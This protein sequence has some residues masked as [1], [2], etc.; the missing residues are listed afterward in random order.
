MTTIKRLV[1]DGPFER[2]IPLTVFVDRC[3]RR[4][5]LCRYGINDFEPLLHMYRTLDEQ[6]VSQGLPPR[7]DRLRAW[8]MRLTTEGFNL[9]AK[10][11]AYV[12][13][14]ANVMKNKQDAE[15]ATQGELALFVHQDYQGAGLGTKLLMC[16]VAIATFKGYGRLWALVDE[17]NRPVIAVNQKLGFQTLTITWG[18]REMELRLQSAGP[19]QG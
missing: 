6:C 5:H 18:E 11:R 10:D 7:G 17:E 9:I 14:H 4:L 19:I 3:G 15:N 12:V 13:G 8:L 16:L 1:A 2:S